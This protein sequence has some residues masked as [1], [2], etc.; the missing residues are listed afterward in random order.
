MPQ[1][2]YFLPVIASKFGCKLDVYALLSQHR[3]YDVTI[4]VF[5][6]TLN[7]K[8]LST[9]LCCA[10]MNRISCSFLGQSHMIV[11]NGLLKIN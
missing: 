8:C 2:L 4:F 5:H 6:V 10:K 9:S 11:L 3:Y 1:P 7:K